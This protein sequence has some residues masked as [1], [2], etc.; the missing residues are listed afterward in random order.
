MNHRI[1]KVK[2]VSVKGLYKINVLFDDGTEQT[3]DMEPLLKGPLFGPLKDVNLFRQV[4]VDAEVATIVWPNGADF[5]P[6]IL[7]EWKKY[8]LEFKMR[9]A[10]W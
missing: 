8:E 7:Y 4:Q 6:A 1:V 10:Q 5:D 9:A 3:I 2:S